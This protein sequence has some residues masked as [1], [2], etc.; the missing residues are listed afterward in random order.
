VAR[1]WYPVYGGDEEAFGAQ[2]T[3]F[4]DLGRIA[5]SGRQLMR[6]MRASRP[7]VRRGAS[8]RLLGLLTAFLCVGLLASGP[9]R[10]AHVQNTSGPPISIGPDAD[11]ASPYPSSVN[12][13]GV[14]GAITKVSVDVTD[15]SHTFPDDIDLALVSPS[16]KATMLMSDAGS[17][18]GPA[19]AHPISHVSLGFDDDAAAPLSDTG[20]ITTGFFRPSNYS[21]VSPDT[22]DAFPTP[23]PTSTSTSLSQYKSDSP[24]GVWSLYAHDDA[25]GDGGGIAAGWTLDITTN[26]TLPQV[27]IPGPGANVTSGPGSPYPLNVN[28]SGKPGVVSKVTAKMTGLSH[29]C[30]D[31]IDALLVSPGGRSSLLMSDVGGCGALASSADLTFDDAAPNVLTT[32]GPLTTGTYRPSND[33]AGDTFP[34]PAPPGP[35][36]TPLSVFD[37]TPPNGTWKLYTVDDGS[38]DAGGIGSF[39]LNVATR[40]PATQGASG[41]GTSSTQDKN[42]PVASLSFASQKLGDVLSSRLLKVKV[43]TS[44]AGGLS[45]QA[46]LG[47]ALAKQL[48]LPANGK[49]YTSAKKAKAKPAII[50][51]GARKVP[52]A[53]RY[54]LTLKLTRK[55]AKQL[56]GRR[57]V[58]LGIRV[59]VTDKAGNRKLVKKG[60]T[61]KR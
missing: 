38:E 23:G 25:N 24:N 43:R 21:P 29:S 6:G 46:V 13:T 53:G 26:S 11:A 18:L 61:L 39:T 22:T 60:L 33:S 44:E 30:P 49:V 36:T 54:T 20:Q 10:A 8:G 41:S 34:A 45:G 31:D 57:K 27:A 56:A 40:I 32:A 51:K 12:V 42:P 55:S 52:K 2:S 3:D 37:G 50:A 14:P 7:T 19:N 4:I 48:G 47:K 58:K 1:W 16:G 35:Y 17:G 5:A 59:R 28:V 15:V 9:A